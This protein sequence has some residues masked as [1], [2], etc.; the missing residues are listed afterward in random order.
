MACAAPRGRRILSTDDTSLLR[1]V[2]SSLAL[3]LGR[4]QAYEALKQINDHLEATVTQ[5]TAELEDARIQL[6]QW[7]KMASLGVLAAGVAHELN[8]PLEVVISTANQ[9][10]PGLGNR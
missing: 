6:F 1:T 9:A 7:E 2:A 5:R 3:A 4:A 8:T 10:D